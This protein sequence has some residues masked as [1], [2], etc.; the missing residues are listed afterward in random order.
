MAVELAT[1]YV[2]LVPSARGIGAAVNKELTGPT[3]S[4]AKSAGAKASQ[5]FSSS[6]GST[7][8]RT[9]STIL[10]GLGLGLA[11]LGVAATAFGKDFV[12][13]AEESNKVAAQTRA[14]LK[15]TGGAANVSA[16]QIGKLA[17]QLS[18]KS[19]IDDEVIQSGENVLA[20]FT[21]IR[22]E[23]GKGNDIF[24]QATKVTLDMSVA[25][26]EDLKNANIQVGK[27]LNDPI[28]GITA[29]RRVGVSFTQQQQDQI[30]TLVESGDK[31]SAQKIILRELATEFGGSAAAQATASDKLKVVWGNLEETLGRKL[32]PAVNA[33][34][35]W[36]Q[37]KGI[38]AIASAADWVQ[39]SLVP[40][41]QNLARWV[42]ENVVPPL[43]TMATVLTETIIPA[44]SSTATWVND[45][46]V[47]A[48]STLA[49]VLGRTNDKAKDGGP[50]WQG[51]VV[52]S[53]AAL[54]AIAG[55]G[56]IVLGVMGKL[57]P[58]IQLVTGVLDI[59]TL[60][61][62]FAAAPFVIFGAT[63]AGIVIFII[64]QWSRIT[65]FFAGLWER[66]S[67]IFRNAA[68]ALASITLSGLIRVL[69]GIFTGGMSEIVGLVVRH[70]GQIRATFAAGA[71]AV[72][73]FMRALP[74]RIGGALAALPG[75]LSRAGVAA[76]HAFRSGIASGASAAVSFV[77]SIPSRLVGALGNARTLLADAGRAIVHGFVDGIKS[78]IG[79]AVGA[80]KSLG[81]SVV[82]AGKSIL[83]IGSPSTVFAGIG[84]EV[85]AGFVV[86]LGQGQA[87]ARSAMG[88]LVRPPITAAASLGTSAATSAAGA[89]RAGPAV[90]IENVNL[91]D[92]TDVDLL[93]QRL[94]FLVAGGRL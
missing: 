86:G 53:G 43:Q 12:K 19:G 27:A 39:T 1:A 41:L 63:V 88:S 4:I 77:G 5:S 11:G 59:L 32:L 21:S 74:G 9:G 71:G 68:S 62:T 73:G 35:T 29:L 79:E 57:W 40:A 22:N 58:A 94:E 67:G 54:I 83:G 26:G 60:A 23:V 84:Q 49:D 75:I 34:S 48:F 78:A 38:P 33:F 52:A 70:W 44:L 14:V 85:V 47:P 76:F 82:S 10:K 16:A 89:G 61:V 81:S 36:L 13:A 45:H 90:N 87:Q 37:T 56:A 20:T 3:A 15:S 64:H 51:W 69:V 31:L 17:T 55:A 50:S 18:L 46:L 24:T 8:K 42:R 30:K 28:R 93:S 25:L 2:S 66:V 80:V 72:V 7:L 91:N 92:G 6:F 65:G